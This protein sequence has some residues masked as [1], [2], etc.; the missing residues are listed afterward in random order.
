[1]V[2]RH[3][4]R[5]GARLVDTPQPR[6]CARVGDAARAEDATPCAV[7]AQEM[8]THILSAGDGDAR[9]EGL[10]DGEGVVAGV[11]AGLLAGR[12]MH[13]PAGVVAVP[14][15]RLGRDRPRRQR[16]QRRH[17][18][19]R[20]SER[21]RIDAQREIPLPGRVVRR[22]LDRVGARLVDTPQPRTCARVG[23]AARAEERDPLCRRR[24]GDA[25]SHSQRWRR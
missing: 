23:D 14:R 6:T 17:T 16:A 21:H 2:R 10:R 11:E 20:R 24:S 1:M 22:H 9:L 5:V 18:A 4:D 3:L 12:A 8:P 7:A 13:R 15:T 19:L 25:N